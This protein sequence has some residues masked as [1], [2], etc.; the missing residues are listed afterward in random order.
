MSNHRTNVPKK[1]IYVYENGVHIVPGA[2]FWNGKLPPE[3]EKGDIKGWSEDS[4]L[5]M[6]KWAMTHCKPSGWVTVSLDLTFPA[7][8]RGHASGACISRDDALRIF[9]GF[10]I[11][12]CRDGGG[13]LWRLEIQPRKKTKRAD[14]RG[15]PQ[16][17][18]HC[19]GCVPAG[20]DLERLRGHWLASLGERGQ[21]QGASEHAINVNDCGDWTAARY[22]Y[23]IDHA[24]KR[25]A[26][27]VASGWGRHWGVVGRARFE[28][29][30]GVELECTERESVQLLRAVAE[31]L[32]RRVKDRRAVG[33]VNWDRVKVT[34]GASGVLVEWIGGRLFDR[35]PWPGHLTPQLQNRVAVAMGAQKLN[36]WALRKSKKRSVNGYR[37]GVEAEKILERIRK[38][39]EKA[40]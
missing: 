5:R 3:R 33:G 37:F 35:S 24:S 28:F 19:I 17:H 6:K 1:T 39:N 10:T 9:H 7:L 8:G 18:Y 32:R 26:E 23:L 11:R 27:Q 15:V 38:N 22:R 21:V 31:M 14:I 29:Q 20:Y 4:R 13:F 40:Q 36:V 34:P 2:R 25:K 16:P 30:P 12:V